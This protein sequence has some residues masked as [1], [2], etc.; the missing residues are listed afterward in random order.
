MDKLPRNVTTS[1]A[2]DMLLETFI[3]ILDALGKLVLRVGA[4]MLVLPLLIE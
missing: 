4:Q 1:S 2:I 3:V